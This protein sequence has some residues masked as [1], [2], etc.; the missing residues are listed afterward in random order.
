MQAYRSHTAGKARNEQLVRL[1]KAHTYKLFHVGLH[2]VAVTS[3]EALLGFRLCSVGKG[4]VHPLDGAN[5]VS[6][7]QE[8]SRGMVCFTKI[9]NVFR[10]HEI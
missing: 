2:K 10:K 7:L 1:G 8:P 9:S 6:H 4:D 5:I 3:K